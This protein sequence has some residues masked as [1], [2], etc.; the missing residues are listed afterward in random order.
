VDT[1][2]LAVG[3]GTPTNGIGSTANQPGHPWNQNRQVHN[4]ERIRKV[5]FNERAGS[6]PVVDSW[7][8]HK[9][10]WFDITDDLPRFHPAHPHSLIRGTE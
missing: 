3:S 10:P 1:H 9:T 7:V 2:L 8:G 6:R 4:Y 5:G